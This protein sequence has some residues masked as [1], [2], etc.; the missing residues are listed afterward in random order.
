[1]SEG[2]RARLGSRLSL[3]G[4]LVVA[5][6]VDPRGS[7]QAGVHVDESERDYRCWPRSL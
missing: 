6:V 1:M 5:M 7:L 4:G 3:A 2:L